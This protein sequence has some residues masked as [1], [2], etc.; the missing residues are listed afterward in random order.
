MHVG[1]VSVYVADVDRA[2]AFFVE[3]LGCEVRVDEPFEGVHRW[4]MLAPPNARTALLLVHGFAEWS[5]DRVGGFTGHAFEVAD[6]FE[7]HRQWSARGITFTE[8]PSKQSYG[9]WAQ[10]EDSEGNV[11]GLHSP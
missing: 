5:P 8:A 4:V 7:T 1:F 9:A 2:K 6:V 3:K 10:F 11:W